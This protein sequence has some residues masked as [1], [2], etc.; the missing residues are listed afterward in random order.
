MA[1]IVLGDPRL[2]GPSPDRD[3]QMCGKVSIGQ[4]QVVPRCFAVNP[5]SKVG[6]LEKF[7]KY[8]S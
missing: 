4:E 5:H 7:G 8:A 3:K 6:K 1:W 2:A